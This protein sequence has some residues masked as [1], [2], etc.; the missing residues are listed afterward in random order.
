M[1]NITSEI[2]NN[3]VFVFYETDTGLT[4]QAQVALSDYNSEDE[5]ITAATEM[6]KQ[7][8]EIYKQDT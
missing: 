6:A 3:T 2:I 4:F 8:Y 1:G 5:A 7:Y